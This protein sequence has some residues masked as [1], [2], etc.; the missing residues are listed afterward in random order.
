MTFEQFVETRQ[1]HPDNFE[2]MNPNA[3]G[4]KGAYGYVDNEY[5]IEDVS[6]WDKPEMLSR[7]RWH[8]CIANVDW[9][10]DDLESL[11]RRLW[12][13]AKDWLN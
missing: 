1:Y 7:G 8:L 3:F 2:A 10:S 5:Y 9:F 12:D 13:F 4:A 11:E 6:T